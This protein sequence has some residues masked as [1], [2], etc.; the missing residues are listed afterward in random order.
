[1]EFIAN[2]PF[3]C[4]MIAMVGGIVSSVLKPKIAQKLNVIVVGTCFLLSVTLLI[5]LNINP[6]SFTYMMGHYEAPWGNEIRFGPLEALMATVLSLVMFIINIS[7][8]E[9]VLQNVPEEKMHLFYLMMNLLLSSTFAL[10][11]TN[12]LFTAYVFI[13]INTLCACGF[14]M[15]KETGKTIAATI[16]YLIM[17]LL[18]S[19]LFLLSIILI[20]DLTGH[21]LMPNVK[22]SLEILVTNQNYQLPITVIVIL[23]AVGIAIKSALFPFHSWVPNAYNRAMNLSNALSAGLVLKSYII[24]L[25]KFFYRVLGLEIVKQLQVTN[26]LFFFGILAM[27]I[28]SIDALNEKNIKRMLA[29]SSIA[30][31]GYIFTAIGIGTLDGFIAACFIMMVHSLAKPMLF[32]ACEGL[33]VVSNNTKNINELKGSARR[34][35]IAGLAF[36]IGAFSTIGFPMLAGFTSK[37]LLAFAGITAKT[38][39][40][41]VL[42]AISISTVLNAIYF[43]RVIII[44]YT[45]DEENNEVVKNSKSYLTGMTMFIIINLFLGFFNTT[46]LQII[47][48][49]LELL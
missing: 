23:L 26:L 2:F 1:M 21:L 33:M 3:F 4:I 5:Y 34:N 38:Q 9:R 35:K 39:M 31:I 49:G 27:V 44:I 25:I 30:Q 47:K 13:E 45:K 20:Y 40:W 24:L 28:G 19:G 22:E 8:R 46:T 10:I 36:T 37:Y 17:S 43:L 41:Y 42:I 16:K 12:D 6:Q 48:Q 11:Y 14:V 15:A 7:E 32:S 29:Y 18:G